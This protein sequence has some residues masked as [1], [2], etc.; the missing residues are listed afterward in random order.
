MRKVVNLFVLAPIA[1]VLILLSVANR[2]TVTF[3]LD[4]TNIETPAIAFDLP[5]FVFLFV[6]FFVGIFVG[7]T[8]TWFKQGKHRKAARQNAFEANM[9]KQENIAAKEKENP[10]STEIAP[11]LPAVRSN[12]A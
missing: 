9:L 6:T 8:L 5:F 10:A 3:S 4:P 12:S 2:Q 7:S 11:G 1:V